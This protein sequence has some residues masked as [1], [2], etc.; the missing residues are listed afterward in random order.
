MPRKYPN[1]TEELKT[2]LKEFKELKKPTVAKLC[3]EL[4]FAQRKSLYEYMSRDDEVGKAILDAWLYIL[5]KHE[6]R[7]Y[8]RSPTGSIFYLK[9]MSWNGWEY[10]DTPTDTS[11]KTEPTKITIEVVDAK[12]KDK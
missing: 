7:L 12:S 5:E 4:K 10:I 1:L 2:K 8:E 11:D 6:E 9:C 3:R